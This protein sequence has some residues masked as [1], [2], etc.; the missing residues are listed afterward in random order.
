MP[1]RPPRM[2][3][4]AIDARLGSAG[5]LGRR[6]ACGFFSTAQNDSS[7]QIS[8]NR[9]VIL[10]GADRIFVRSARSKD[11]HFVFIYSFTSPN[12]LSK[13]A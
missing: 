13:N 4:A 3:G 9:S 5:D 10:S 2:R 8:K 12:S 7:F 6:C 11:L 1:Q